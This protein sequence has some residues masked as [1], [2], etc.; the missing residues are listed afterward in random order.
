MG[1]FGV[2]MGFAAFILIREEGRT[3]AVFLTG[4]LAAALT[5]YVIEAVRERAEGSQGTHR[6]EPGRVLGLLVLLAVFEIFVS[7]VEQSVALLSSGEASA[8]LDQVFVNGIT[9]KLG[10]V[11]QLVL[12]AGLW[13]VLGGAAAWS[14]GRADP[15]GA[16]STVRGALARIG[17]GLALVAGIALAYVLLTR[18]AITI[19]VLLTRPQEYQPAFATLVDAAPSGPGAIMAQLPILLATGLEALAGTGRWGGVLLLLAVVGLAALVRPVMANADRGFGWRILAITLVGALGLLALGP[20]ATSGAQFGRLVRI[21][22]ASTVIWL[23]PLV[24]L[25]V[26]RP[27]LG[28]PARSPRVWGIVAFVVALLLVAL[29]WDRIGEPP[30]PLYVGTLVVAMCVTGWLFLRGADVVR[31]WPLVALTLALAAFE[32]STVLQRLTFLTTFKEAAL[33]QGAPV[34]GGDETRVK[35]GFAALEQWHTDSLLERETIALVREAR[36]LD[37]DDATSA[38]QAVDRRVTAAL[39]SLY[40]LSV[41]SVC[42]PSGA[43]FLDEGVADA[44]EACGAVRGF[45]PGVDDAGRWKTV[46]DSVW[47]RLQRGPWDG[48]LDA[49]VS[50][51]GDALQ[52]QW[53]RLRWGDG[54][55]DDLQGAA[56]SVAQRL[57]DDLRTLDAAAAMQRARADVAL[58]DSVRGWLLLH[59]AAMGARPGDAVRGWTDQLEGLPRR[60]DGRLA[61]LPVANTTIWYHERHRRLADLVEGRYAAGIPGPLPVPFVRRRSGDAYRARLRA[62]QALGFAQAQVRAHAARGAEDNTLAADAGAVVALE[63]ALGASFAFW[64]TAGLLAGMARREPPAP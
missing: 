11:V 14:V 42:A 33:L 13:V 23:V 34:R 64:T 55:S 30:V 49:A 52:F 6:P 57:S 25:A 27:G 24:V 56:A 38:L 59:A 62:I 41:D 45:V 18:L 44:R 39:D 60:E 47:A 9:N 29:T 12:F 3:P 22:G 5:S 16:G 35:R 63:L 51:G 36:S 20:F 17:I 15:E 46:W 1:A 31:F 7:G 32:G 43:V 21:V 26:A 40:T 8:F 48:R 19:W 53:Y 50:N 58:P 10:A 4:L 28:G 61:G 54:G 37:D 2:V